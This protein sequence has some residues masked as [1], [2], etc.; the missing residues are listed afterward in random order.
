VL[1]EPGET[2]KFTVRLFDALGEF[3]GESPGTFSLN[4]PGTIGNDG[5]YTAPA[6][7]DH[8]A[9]IVTAKVGDLEAQAR[10]RVVPPLPWR[11]DFND[12]DD[13][14]LTWVGGRVRYILRDVDGKRIMV[15]RDELPTRPGQPP[16]KLGAKSRMWMG[17]VD[18]SNYTIQA[19]IQGQIKDGKMPDVGLINQRYTLSL[20]GA[21]QK[22]HLRSWAASEHRVSALVAFDWKPNVW[23][24]MKLTTTVVDGKAHVRGKVWPRDADEPQSW[25]VQIVDDSPN[26][27]G[28]PGLYGNARD[29]EF[30]LDN[31]VVIP[32]E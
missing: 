7:N 8:T 18:L 26:L 19:D 29:A 10:L 5:T 25:T 32:N 30:F 20:Q 28:S 24:T 31:L 13:V 9:T 2:Q 27:Q 21:A 4:G 11:Y 6:G 15:K 22:L 17:Q 14:P 1:L 23:Y 12:A 16:T 3:I